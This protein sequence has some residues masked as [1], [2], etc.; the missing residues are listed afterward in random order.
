MQIHAARRTYLARMAALGAAVLLVSHVVSAWQRAANPD[1]PAL[2]WP[3][4]G[5]ALAGMI[6][7]GRGMWPAFFLPVAGSCLFAGMPWLF[8]LAAPAAV[9]ASLVLAQAALAGAGFDPAFARLRDTINFLV[10]GSLLPMVLAGLG[11][12]GAMCLAGMAPWRSLFAVSAIYGA[13]YATG[14]ALLTPPI[15]L[16]RFRRPLLRDWRWVLPSAALVVCIWASFSGVLP[17]EGKLM[18]YAPFPFLVWAA[19]AGGLPSAAAASLITVAA[20]IGFSASGTGPFAGATGLAMF[21]QIEAYIAVMATTSLIAGAA[22]E[23]Q[24]RET[25]MQVEAANREAESERLKS[26]LQPH[27]LF[28]CLAAIHSLAQTDPEAARGGIV[29]L[30]DLLRASLEHV[31]ENRIPL[32]REMRFV[33][34]YLDLQRMRFEETLQVS[35]VCDG[36]AGAAFVPPMLVQPLVENA[37]KHGEPKDGKLRVDVEVSLD[38]DALRI[39]VGNSAGEILP[40]PEVSGGVGLRN[41]RERLILAWG[42]AAVFRLA[43]TRPGWIEA[44]ICVSRAAL[45]EGPSARG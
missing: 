40:P 18:S 30:A 17:G 2:V 37:L 45:D 38:E 25:E 35:L 3:A 8:S 41:L 6:V 9:T 13:A 29:L 31:S 32:E 23:S 21:A 24:T 42:D 1:F 34:T 16:A 27:F 5:V 26:Q 36:A 33:R 12:A 14:A 11:T 15:L 7:W 4:Q 39:N 28:N 10:R 43:Q 19:W 20:A 44:S 22:A